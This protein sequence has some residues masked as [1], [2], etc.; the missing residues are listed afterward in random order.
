[1]VAKHADLWNIAGGDIDD[2][3]QRSARLDRYC[4]ELGRDPA[5]ITRSMHLSVSYDAPET[6]RAAIAEARD[7]GF[8]HF[9]LSLSPPYPD[10]VARWLADAVIA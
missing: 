3:V 1:M 4:A 10:G 6:T 7:A 2:A 8:T 5:T 9:V